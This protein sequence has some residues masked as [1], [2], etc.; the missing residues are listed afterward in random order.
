MRGAFN[1]SWKGGVMQRSRRGN[2][3]THERLVRCPPG[4]S[5]M[6]RSNGYVLEHRLVVAQALGRPLSRG[7]VVHH[8]NHDPMDNRLENLA[9]FASNRDH[10]LHEAHGTPAPL[11]CGSTL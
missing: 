5:T 7:E 6:A 1:P 4:F 9:L 3:P 11:W 2:Y 10:K 8:M